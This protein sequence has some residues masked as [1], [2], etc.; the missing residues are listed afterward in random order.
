MH[1]ASGMVSCTT[2]ALL[3][4]FAADDGI[5]MSVRVAGSMILHTTTA[6]VPVF[7]ALD[8]VCMHMAGSVILHTAAALVPVFATLDSVCVNMAGS[9]VLVTTE[10]T[11]ITILTAG[12]PAMIAALTTYS[13]NTVVVGVQCSTGSFATRALLPVLVCIGLPRVGASMRVAISMVLCTAGA[14]LAILATL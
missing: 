3:A 12:Y 2:A 11:L 10:A 8:S 4:V 9:M 13:A 5:G 14:L 6:L 7:A 1:V